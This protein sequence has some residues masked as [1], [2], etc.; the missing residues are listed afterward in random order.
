MVE[1][2][3]HL[4]FSAR[5]KAAYHCICPKVYLWLSLKSAKPLA[6]KSGI[7]MPCNPAF[8]EKLEELLVRYRNTLQALAKGRPEIP[9]RL[10]LRPGLQ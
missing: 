3:S 6:K 10:R 7:L 4:A 2:E 5:F 8:E 9:H 1:K